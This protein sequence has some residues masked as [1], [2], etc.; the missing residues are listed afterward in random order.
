VEEV[1]APKLHG[2]QVLHHLFPDGSI[3]LMVLFASTSTVT[4][5]AGQV[6]YVAANE[7]L[8]AYAKARSGGKTRVSR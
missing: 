7:Y 6:D 3:A 4:G 1:F 2:T 8:N 5:P